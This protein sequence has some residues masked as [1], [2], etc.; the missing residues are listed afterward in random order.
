[1]TNLFSKKRNILKQSL[2]LL[3]IVVAIGGAVSTAY[4]YK[5]YTKIKENPNVV[6]NEEV[7]NLSDKVGKLIKLPEDE[8]PTVATIMDKSKLEN[9]P[10]YSKSEN[11]DKILVYTKAMKAI[12][13]RPS[14][15]M[16]I[17]VMPIVFNQKKGNGIKPM[18]QKKETEAQ[19]GKEKNK[20]T[21]KE[22]NQKK[23]K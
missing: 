10:F 7:K 5:E 19:K 22:K 15:N 14:T 8:T 13:Y 9:D 2:I 23:T 18:E 11:G 16:I 4:F 17:E 1:M 21:K 20:E 3:L 6:L 12:L